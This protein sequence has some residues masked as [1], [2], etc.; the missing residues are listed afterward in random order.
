MFEILAVDGKWQLWSP[1]D[2]CNV[3]CGGGGQ[4]RYRQCVGPYFGG[5][6]CVGDNEESLDCGMQTCP[7]KE[8]RVVSCEWVIFL[9]SAG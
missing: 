7:G 3:T 1:W 4:Q 5:Q 2:P 8:H 6:P 9:V